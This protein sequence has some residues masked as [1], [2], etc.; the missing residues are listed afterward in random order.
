MYD[1]P[2]KGA[3]KFAEVEGKLALTAAERFGMII[4]PTEMQ[5]D[6]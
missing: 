6:P 5:A 3:H 4:E 1:A 2:V